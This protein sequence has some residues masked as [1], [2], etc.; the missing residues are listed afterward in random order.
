M[1][2]KL[3]TIGGLHKL[4]GIDVGLLRRMMDKGQ[5]PCVRPP[6]GFH[7]RILAS[8]LPEVLAKLEAFGLL[9]PAAKQQQQK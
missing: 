7:R 9:E 3:M 1:R 5:L 8:Q 4:T 6:G 2:D